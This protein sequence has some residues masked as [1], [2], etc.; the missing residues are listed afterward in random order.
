MGPNRQGL[1]NVHG[2]GT[3]SESPLTA[4]RL[5]RA[6]RVRSFI[7]EAVFVFVTSSTGYRRLTTADGYTGDK[8]MEGTYQQDTL[9]LT[10]GCSIRVHHPPGLPESFD[11]RV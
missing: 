10:T 1:V 6:K 2:F 7:E 11:D 8:V 3:E 4:H 9:S 5:W